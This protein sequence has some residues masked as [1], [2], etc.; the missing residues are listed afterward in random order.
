MNSLFYYLLNQHG[1]E[2][3]PVRCNERTMT[4]LVNS[5]EDVVTEN[6]LSALVIEGKCL[7]EEARQERE[8]LTQL[9]ASALQVYLFAFDEPCPDHT[10]MPSP[11]G[12]LEL[13]AEKEAHNLEAGPFILVMDNRFCGLLVSYAIPEET[14]QLAKTYEI[15][16]SFDI[17]VVYSAIEYLMARIIASKPDKRANI[18][19]A[20][21][22]SAPSV[23]SYKIA[24]SFI[25]R[26]AMFMQRQNELEMAMNKISYTISNTLEIETVLQSAVEEIGRVLKARQTKLTLVHEAQPLPD[27]GAGQP[28]SGAHSSGAHAAG[29]HAAGAEGPSE[30][31]VYSYTQTARRQK[32]GIL[33]PMTASLE[34]AANLASLEVPIVYRNQA[35]G[36]LSI[37]DDT[38]G[39]VWESEEVL[40]LKTVSAQLAVAISHAR[41]F[42]QM[43]TQAITDSLTG[44]YN[45]RYFQE[46]L[47]REIKI[48][49]RHHN[50]VSLILLDLD[51]LKRINDTHGHRTGDEVLSIV[52]RVLK[53]NVR[54]IDIC[55]RYGGEEF[56]ILLPQCSRDDAIKTAE[57]LRAAIAS[58]PVEKVGQITASIGVASYPVTAQSKEELIDMAD[59]AMYMAKAAGR[60]RVRTTMHLRPQMAKN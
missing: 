33:S 40:I 28:D 44:L 38:P 39:R 36:S 6:K 9:C 57:R 55:A 54:E 27:D 23:I 37:V 53:E 22:A 50:P 5:F 59:Q 42:R 58:T 48:A 15:I 34:D 45:H 16:W 29:A 52:S 1:D 12:N 56:V 51:Y 20:L 24:F 25:T 49:D 8:R 32:T 21:N 11:S 46:S 31:T 41:L 2:F 18:E 13:F 19:E 43:Q 4:R 7:G 3:V 14:A 26:L 30:Q 35:I 47:E 10:W 17:N 60:N